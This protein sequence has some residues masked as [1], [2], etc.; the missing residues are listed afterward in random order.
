MASSLEFPRIDVH[1][2]PGTSRELY[3]KVL[4]GALDAALIVEPD[5]VIPKV[6]D[7]QVL[8]EEPLVAISPEGVDGDLAHMLSA[9]P[10]IR[11][12]R[13]NWGGRLADLYLR[14]NGIRPRERFELDS[15]DAIAVL[16]DR[17]LGVS[18]V[19]DWAPPWPSGLSLKKRPIVDAG[20]AR[21]LGM[22][23]LRAS[24]Q[25]HLVTAFVG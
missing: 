5:F 9:S 17:G 3:P 19:P 22:L 16:V 18:L 21:R 10:F 15:L 14:R 13:S 24:A 25:S 6:C 11:Y 7:W 20:Y 23:S 2:S 1:V 4:D 8:R 12:D